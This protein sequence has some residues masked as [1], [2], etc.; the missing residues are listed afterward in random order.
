MLE[1]SNDRSIGRRETTRNRNTKYSF[2][3]TVRASKGFLLHSPF[4]EGDASFLTMHSDIPTRNSNSNF[5]PVPL[6]SGTITRAPR[7]PEPPAL[8]VCDPHSE[9]SSRKQAVVEEWRTWTVVDRER[10]KSRGEQNARTRLNETRLL[11]LPSSIY[12]SISTSPSICSFERRSWVKR[13]FFRISS[14]ERKIIS[15]LFGRDEFWT[16]FAG[17]NSSLWR[18]SLRVPRA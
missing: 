7:K 15:T 13:I 9:R 14:W 18:V 1:G 11:T 16:R 10:K 3:S 2:A 6:R 12:P 5:E 8:C 17:G 4:P